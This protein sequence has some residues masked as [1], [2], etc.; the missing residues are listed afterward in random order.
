MRLTAGKSAPVRRAALLSAAAGAA[1]LGA[2]CG[3]EGGAASAAEGR[4]QPPVAVTLATVA[5]ED[6][7]LTVSAI[8]WV[9]AFATVTVKPQVSGQLQGLHFSEGEEVRAGQ[10][11]ITIDARPF[12]SALHLA[13]ATRARDAALAENAEQEAVRVQG[14]FAQGQASER[15]RDDARFVA[16]SKAA[17]VRADEAEM[18][19]AGLDV[20]YCTI[21]APLDGRAGSYLVNRGNVVKANETELVVINQLAP[22]YV[23]FSVP[24]RYLSEIRAAS[25]S[26]PLRVEVSSDDADAAVETGTLTFIDNQV[27]KSTGMVR[28][29]A[30][31]PN[32]ERRLW[33]GRFARVTL[34][35]R[36]LREAAVAPASAVQP[37]QG[38]TFV[39]V[40]NADKTVSRVDVTAG[41]TVEGKTVIERGLTGGE[42]VVTDGHLRLVPGMRIE[43]KQPPATGPARAAGPMKR[44]FVSCTREKDQRTHV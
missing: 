20:E 14:L 5:R 7:P 42:T 19:R 31:T 33:P 30:T 10:L 34:V 8:G 41:P 40:V 36:T 28:L 37:G 18:A 23:T 6:F 39:Y 3:A 16:D 25:A 13:E 4:V 29:K 35:T 32:A 27:D 15:E 12:E 1:W 11:L 43:A 44:R 22:I 9:E 2:G 21:R 26:E 17:Q 38:G 24:E